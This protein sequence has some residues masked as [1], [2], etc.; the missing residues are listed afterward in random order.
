MNLR[1]NDI[2]K[3]ISMGLIL[4]IVLCMLAW[5]ARHHVQNPNPP[6]SFPQETPPPALEPVHQYY[7]IS[8]EYAEQTQRMELEDYL[9][10]VVLAEMPASFELEALK[11]QAVAARTYT[12]KRT[13][14]GTRHGDGII[15]ADH[16]CC[17]A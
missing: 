5:R 16:A 13:M 7:F 17:H 2:A 1:I 12:I 3:L 15:C 11:A 10:G 6:A 14:L 9:V 8:L 4:P